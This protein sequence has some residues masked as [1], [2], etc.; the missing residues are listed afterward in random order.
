MGGAHEQPENTGRGIS[1]LRADLQLKQ[2][3]YNEGWPVWSAFCYV[4]SQLWNC[5]F[6]NSRIVIFTIQEL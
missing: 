1:G 6:D 3:I 4:D 5:V 2:M